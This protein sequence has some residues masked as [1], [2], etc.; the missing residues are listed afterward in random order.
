LL[1]T[2]VLVLCLAETRER[3]GQTEWGIW[4]LPIKS[5]IPS[6]SSIWYPLFVCGVTNMF[7]GYLLIGRLTTKRSVLFAFLGAALAVALAALFQSPLPRLYGQAGQNTVWLLFLF[8]A[9]IGAYAGASIAQKPG[10]TTP[11]EPPA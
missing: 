5:W 1:A 6:F 8:F 11:G 9:L 7:A 3:F 4:W 2:L 10:R